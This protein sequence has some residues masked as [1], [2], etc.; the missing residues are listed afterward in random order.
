MD[1]QLDLYVGILS[2]ALGAEPTADAEARVTRCTMQTEGHN[3]S[4]VARGG[5]Q[6]WE[7]HVPHMG[8]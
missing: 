5:Q 6:C 3:V 8:L 1:L 7:G 2:G 4:A